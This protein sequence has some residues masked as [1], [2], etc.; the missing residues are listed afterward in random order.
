MTS[1]LAG[2]VI[3]A[4]CGSAAAP[5]TPEPLTAWSTPAG[6]KSETI[7]FPLGFAPSLTHRG[8]EEI[9]FAPR[10]FEPE[11]PGYWSYVFV[12]RTEDPAV[13]DAAGL[14]GELATY[15]KGLVAAVDQDNKITARDQISVQAVADGARLQLAVHTFDAF[16]TAQPIDLVGWAQRTACG[17][18]AL[19]VFVLAPASSTLRTE[20]D[21]LAATARC[22][23]PVM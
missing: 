16:K 12:W 21:A 13:L 15:F 14:A 7:P 18:G 19:W 22:G 8:T 5:A 11:A 1:R 2:L 17:G 4:A 10:F 23:Q 20:L 3:M 9:R 6:W